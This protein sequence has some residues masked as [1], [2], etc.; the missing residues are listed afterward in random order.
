MLKWDSD[1]P[2]TFKPGYTVY[3]NREIVT[4][5]GKRE[6]FSVA[7]KYVPGHTVHDFDKRFRLEDEGY[8]SADDKVFRWEVLDME[9][10]MRWF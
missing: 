2:V 6:T 5:E 7:V 3:K 10:N 8:I 9:L 4:E 1:S